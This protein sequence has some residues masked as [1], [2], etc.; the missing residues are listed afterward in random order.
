M[1]VCVNI[2]VNEM[3]VAT[4]T[5]SAREQGKIVIYDDAPSCANPFQDL[6]SPRQLASCLRFQI[7]D[8]RGF[9]WSCCCMHGHMAKKKCQNFIL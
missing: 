6:D 8:C 4:G 7:A 2:C 9:M 3:W 1:A 5:K